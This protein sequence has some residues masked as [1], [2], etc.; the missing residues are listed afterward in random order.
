MMDGEVWSIRCFEQSKT[1]NRIER[2]EQFDIVVSNQ[3]NNSVRSSNVHKNFIAK[4]EKRVNVGVECYSVAG[5]HELLVVWIVKILLDGVL[6]GFEMF[7]V[8]D[9]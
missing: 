9:L 1:Q 2:I 4:L 6:I 5:V 8:E 3:M 7:R